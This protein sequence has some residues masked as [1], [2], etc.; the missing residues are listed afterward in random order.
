MKICPTC[1]RTYDDDGLNFCLEDGSVLTFTADAAPTVVMHQ[2]R[3]TGPSPGEGIRTSWDAQDA[4]A[5]SMQPKKKS[6]KA[7]VW[8][9]GILGLVVILCGGGVAGFFVYVASIANTNVA[10]NTSKG[11]TSNT[12]R[13]NTFTSS[14]PSPSPS[15][16][17][18]IQE[19]DLASHVRKD[20][21]YGTT[22]F[23][24]GE[25]LMASK[26]KGYYYV[27][28][29]PD[30]YQT[31]A[32]LTRV[33]VR[34][35]DNAATDLGYGLIIHSDTT[36]LERDYAFLIDSNR[37]RF[38]VVRHE[39]QDEITVTRWRNSSLINPGSAENTIEVRDRGGKIEFYINGQLAT[40]VANKLG[41]TRGV[42]G[43]YVGDGAKI[44]FKK[45]EIAK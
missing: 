38:R 16:P 31:E 44:G 15:T 23:K 26:E 10:V 5:Y 32:A 42:P 19:V 39:P 22:E 14:S 3:S 9:L 13:S 6:S 35:V 36:P 30:D 11:S 1:R 20:S 40:T 24:D 7:W 41:P 21:I 2:P 27:L 8:V 34:N 43:L 29:T 12:S 25:L 45:L 28:V 37:R 17:T 18:E 4:G 33:T